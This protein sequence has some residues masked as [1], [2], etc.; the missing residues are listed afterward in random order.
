MDAAEKLRQKNKR[1]QQRYRDKRKVRHTLMRG[2][3][4]TL[5]TPPLSRHFQ[6]K[7]PAL[8]EVHVKSAMEGKSMLVQ[9]TDDQFEISKR[10]I[11]HTRHFVIHT[12]YTL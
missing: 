3:I 12:N 7:F 2:M 10:T 1:S 4:I 6:F 5:K 11:R 8:R 9:A